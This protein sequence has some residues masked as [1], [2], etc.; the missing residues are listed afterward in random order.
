MQK[1]YRLED[2][3]YGGGASRQI[4]LNTLPPG[5]RVRYIDL[6]FD[7]SGTKD[8][9]DALS[10]EQFARAVALIKLGNYYNIP[11]Y[12][13]FQLMR[14]VEA[15][16]VQQPSDIP[17]VG[18][19]FDMEYHLRLYFRD[20]RQPGSDDGSIPTELLH[21]HSIEITFAAATVWAVGNLTVTAGNVRCQ[22]ELV[23]ETNVPQL[24]V[25]GYID[26]GSATILMQPGVYKDAF[27]LD[28]TGAGNITRAEIESIDMDVD[29]DLV[30]NNALHEQI[31]GAYNA[32]A[33]RD[34]NAE[35]ADNAAERFPLVWH[36]V[37][38]KSNIS[39][40]P[41]AEKQLKIQV[42]G[43]INAN[44]IRVVYWRAI[45]KDGQAVQQIATATGAPEAATEYVPATVSKTVPRAL[46]ERK[47]SG[48]LPRKARLLE[49]VLP[50]KVRR[51]GTVNAK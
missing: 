49:R 8:A 5:M 26:P 6:F 51:P 20:P 1:Y 50:G 34:S 43:S 18:V 21:G 42:T 13:L 48:K 25:V 7:L 17:G 2:V 28:G 38:G 3:T 15:R 10:H 19:T 31:I 33:I 37:F 44:N 23:H 29:G 27:I 11:G 22:A 16:V 41:A 14:Q 32:E 47:A 9:A 45:E 46:A 36:D 12:A 40:Q 30:W 39:K 4:R 24:N 35:L